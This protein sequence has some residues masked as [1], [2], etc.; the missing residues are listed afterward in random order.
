MHLT[1]PAVEGFPV[2]GKNRLDH[3]PIRHLQELALVITVQRLHLDRDHL[4]CLW[5]PAD[6]PEHI[7]VDAANRQGAQHQN[8]RQ[9]QQ[10]PLAEHP[11]GAPQEHQPGNI[12]HNQAQG[13]EE[14][15]GDRFKIHQAHPQVDE[16]RHHQGVHHQE[17]RCQPRI[18]QQV[19][20]AF[21]L[22]SAVE[23]LGQRHEPH[24][25]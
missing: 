16:G 19:P 7:G 9:G 12:A 10:Q 17:H 3:L 20:G 25:H 13:E 1:L 4:V 21:Q 22:P 5:H 23:D 11:G 24:T 14:I 18:G 6:H 8:S 2:V 15:L